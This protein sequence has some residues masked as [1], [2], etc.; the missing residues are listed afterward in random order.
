M[1]DVFKSCIALEPACYHSTQP[2]YVYEI[3]ITPFILQLTAGKRVLGE[4]EKNSS[5]LT[6]RKNHSII[7]KVLV[8]KAQR[9]LDLKSKSF[10][11]S[12]WTFELLWA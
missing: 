6:L 7:W 9:V 3:T 1:Q 4:G 5:P 10:S 8:S 2:V 11:I 12:L